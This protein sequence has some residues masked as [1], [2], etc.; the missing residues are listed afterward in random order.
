[1]SSDHLFSF[2]ASL[3]HIV[4][5]Q[6]LAPSYPRPSGSVLPLVTYLPLLLKT[7]SSLP[8]ADPLLFDVTWS[9]AVGL[10]E[11]ILVTRVSEFEYCAAAALAA[12]S[13]AS[14]SHCGSQKVY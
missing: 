14:S 13:S 5:T 12:L 6:V 1:M 3:F 2:S 4:S 11:T 7:L 8:T 10:L 9:M